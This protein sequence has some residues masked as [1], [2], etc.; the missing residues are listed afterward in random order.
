MLTYVEFFFLFLFCSSEAMDVEARQMEACS[1]FVRLLCNMVEGRGKDDT[2]DRQS[3]QTGRFAGLLWAGEG[4]LGG[5]TFCAPEY[6][7][8]MYAYS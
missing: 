6:K 5:D 7:V 4:Q 3:D 1:I 8:G 2:G